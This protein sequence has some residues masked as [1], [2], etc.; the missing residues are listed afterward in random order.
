MGKV[1]WPGTGIWAKCFNPCLQG[2]LGEYLQHVKACVKNSGHSPPSQEP[3]NSAVGRA[4]DHEN[5]YEHGGM[6]RHGRTSRTPRQEERGR[7]I[8]CVFAGKLFKKL[9]RG[10]DI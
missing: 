2:T 3:I 10:D 5:Q 8:L 1:P 9:W 6:W 4:D 7:F